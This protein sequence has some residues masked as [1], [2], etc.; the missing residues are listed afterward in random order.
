MCTERNESLLKSADGSMATAA[1]RRENK[2]CFTKPVKNQLDS[3]RPSHGRPLHVLTW[4]MSAIA[5]LRQPRR[6]QTMTGP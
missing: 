6:E 3:D 2:R 4:S 1:T 5:M